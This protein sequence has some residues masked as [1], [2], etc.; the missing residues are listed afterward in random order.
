MRIAV[1][2]ADPAVSHVT[3]DENGHALIHLA[4]GRVLRKEQMG[5]KQWTVRR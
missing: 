4:N 2:P 1:I 3:L 5:G